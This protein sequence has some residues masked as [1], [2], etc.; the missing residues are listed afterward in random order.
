MWSVNEWYFV[1]DFVV[2][3]LMPAV[4]VVRMTVQSFIP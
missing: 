1:R 4:F 3:I 2:S